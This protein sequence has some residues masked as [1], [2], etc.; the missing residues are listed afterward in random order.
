METVLINLE[1][2]ADLAF[3]MN[4]VEKLG[5]KAKALTR[6]EVEDWQ[7]EEGMKTPSVKRSEVMKE[8]KK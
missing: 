1:K 6:A 2:K 5:M 3:L 4:L 7:L 8:L